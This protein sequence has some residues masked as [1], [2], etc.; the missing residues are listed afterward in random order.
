MTCHPPPAMG[1]AGREALTFQDSATFTDVYWDLNIKI[2]A[3]GGPLNRR[4]HTMAYF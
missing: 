1:E 3:V 4:P 2:C